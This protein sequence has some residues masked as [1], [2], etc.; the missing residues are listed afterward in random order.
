MPV[1]QAEDPAHVIPGGPAPEDGSDHDP[2][3]D[4]HSPSEAGTRDSLLDGRS[5]ESEDDDDL[6][7][8]QPATEDNAAIDSHLVA[9][10]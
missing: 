7:S 2:A 3:S 9:Q 1:G 4:S 6:V 8:P 10:H 5:G